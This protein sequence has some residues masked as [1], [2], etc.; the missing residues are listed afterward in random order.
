MTIQSGKSLIFIAFMAVM[1]GPRGLLAR[2][3]PEKP[4]EEKKVPASARR[5]LGDPIH[6]LAKDGAGLDSFSVEAAWRRE[7]IVTTTTI[8]GTG[9][10]IWKTSAQFR[11]S[12][13][14]ILSIV[15]KLDASGFGKMPEQLGED[16]DKDQALQMKGRVTVTIAGVTRRVTQLSEGD[17]S[18]ALEKLALEILN[19]SKKALARGTVTASSLSDALGKLSRGELAPETLQLYV[20]RIV[21]HPGEGTDPVGWILHS[22]GRSCSVR[23]RT[24]AKGMGIPVVVRLSPQDFEALVRD[25]QEAEPA[26]FP[27]N[28]YATD[29][30]DFSVKILDRERTLQARRFLNVTPQTHGEK[31]TRFDALYAALDALHRKAMAEGKETPGAD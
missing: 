5:D 26:S 4:G 11:L 22:T 23:E 18:A 25:L 17:Q 27:G 3:E 13:E 16:L 6:R 8:F 9:V 30:T 21:E 19:V 10:G 14:Q 24:R 7:G 2:A 28:L 15:R 12:R 29:Y 20:Q 31:Q 1:A